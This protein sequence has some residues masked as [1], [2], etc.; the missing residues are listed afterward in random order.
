MERLVISEDAVVASLAGFARLL[1]QEGV[2]V[3]SGQLLAWCRGLARLD[4]SDAGDLYWSGRACLVSSRQDLAAYDRVFRRCFGEASGLSGSASGMPS[5]PGLVPAPEVRAAGHGVAPD[6]SPRGL[7]AS[8]AESLRAKRFVDCTPEELAALQ[9]LMGR[10]RLTPPSREVRR[11][12]PS[13][14]GR[15]P[16]LRR[17]IRR[18]LRS[19]GEV[20]WPTW[21]VRRRRP[22]RLVLFLDVSGSMAGYS[23][24]LLQFSHS[25]ASASR[26]RTEVFCF[27]TRLTRV[28]LQ[29][30]DRQADQALAK[31]AEAVVDWE[32]GTR[33]GASLRQFLRVSGRGGLARGAVVV[34]CSDGLERSDPALLA[35]EMARLSR[36]AHRIVWVNPL[37]ADPRYQ[38]LARG[39]GA[40]LPFV[41]VFLSGHDL[42][43]LAALAA[44][45]Q[46]LT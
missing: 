45:L 1:R 3:G 44:L 13:A 29:L 17:T 19:Q 24:A 18:S 30:K 16:D 31:A 4:P 28:T 43:S 6:G 8:D 23:R 37:K 39:M 34:I 10:L 14:R 32:G 46:E 40:A 35:G 26:N 2:T 12:A 5:R 20:L 9:V 15:Y 41:D 38:P 36:L 11:R 7:A 25:A 33:I 27:G 42:S 21:Q 22:R